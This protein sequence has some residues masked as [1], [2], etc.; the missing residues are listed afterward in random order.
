MGNHLEYLSN[1]LERSFP[2]G[3]DADVMT[4]DTLVRIDVETKSLPDEER[5]SNE[6]NVV[7]YLHQNLNKFRTLSYHKDYDYSHLRWT[8]DT[9]E[10]YELIKRIYDTLYPENQNFL[11][12]DILDLLKIYPKWSKINSKIVPKSGFWTDTEK[13]KLNQRLSK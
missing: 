6:I 2:L 4:R 7:P 9:P 3:I 10:D 12:Q 1:C 8:L 13:N 11:M 5:K